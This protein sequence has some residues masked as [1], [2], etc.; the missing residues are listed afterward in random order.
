M[1][2]EA[3]KELT[4][5]LDMYT[6]TPMVAMMMAIIEAEENR[7]FKEAKPWIDMIKHMKVD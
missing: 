1:T 4:A 7:N 5:Y 3:R 6:P 2:D